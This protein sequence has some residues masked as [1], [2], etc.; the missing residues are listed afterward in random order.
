VENG[1]IFSE[2]ILSTS[3]PSIFIGLYSLYDMMFYSNQLVVSCS[4]LGTAIEDTAIGTFKGMKDPSRVLNNLSN[5]FDN[6]YASYIDVSMFM[7]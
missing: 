6:A 1:I 7:S 4:L 3:P 2:N 5:N